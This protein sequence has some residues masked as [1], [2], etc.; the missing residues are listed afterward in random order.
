MI[1]KSFLFTVLI[2]FTAMFAEGQQVIKGTVFMNGK[3][4]S[5][6]IVKAQKGSEITTGSDGK[7][8][9]QAH[10]KT[11]WLQ[12]AYIDQ[13][14]KHNLNGN[15]DSET[16]FYFDGIKPSGTEQNTDASDDV[17]EKS[18]EQL[19]REH[20]QEYID[21]LS[22]YSA[23][24]K[25]G[26]YNSALPHW[27]NI[28]DK[29]PKSHLNIYIQGVRM[30]QAFMDKASANE[31][32]EKLLYE[33]MDI[34]DRRIEYFGDRGYVLG[35]KGVDWL[36]FYVTNQEFESE[37]LKDRIKT[38]YEWIYES[39]NI[40]GNKSEAPV[41]L[42]LMRMSVAL[43]DYNELEKA[44][45]VSIYDTCTTIINAVVSENTDAA[46]VAAM[47]EIQPLIETIFESSGAADCDFLLNIYTPQYK[48]K[49]NDADFLK[50]MLLRLRRA[51]CDDSDLFAM[52]TEKL[53]EIEPSASAA[54]DVAL[55]LVKKNEMA[56]AKEYFILAMEHENDKD[57]LA[58]YYTQ[59]AKIL[60]NENA[61]SEA[62]N[63]ARKI[64]EINPASCEAKILIGDI[65]VSAYRSFDGTSLEKSAI[66]WLAA[67]YYN[68]ASL[69]EACAAEAKQKAN[70]YKIYF[71][72]KEDV[73]MEG[74]QEGDS[75]KIEGWINETTRVRF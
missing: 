25:Q 23:F 65:Y 3:P 29:F 45:I 10:S 13:K 41:L 21:E 54:Y 7:Y 56:K 11:K 75:Y 42:L 9:V 47:K 70:E 55:L 6:V 60:Y 64:L 30:Y 39:V 26:D 74:L 72:E 38:G 31:E 16:D 8:A 32:K 53:Y 52:A 63:Y 49:S 17:T 4:A 37:T 62:R 34:Y 28:Y 66:M 43:S 12:F 15:L 19:V 27:K 22:S 69:D 57:L 36:R 24:F 5:G 1:N 48:E 67:D 71:P 33:L 35:R 50:T 51:N 61:W 2:V 14:K 18:Q 73:F 59:Y 68:S 46:Q 44:N 58:T 40:Q 20:N